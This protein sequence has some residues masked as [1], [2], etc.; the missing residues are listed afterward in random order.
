MFSHWQGH[1]Q[2]KRRRASAALN[3]YA[4]G[5]MSQDATKCHRTLGATGHRPTKCSRGGHPNFPWSVCHASA[6][7]RY[8]SQS[9]SHAAHASATTC[10][11]EE[12]EERRSTLQQQWQQTQPAEWQQTSMNSPNGET[13]SPSNCE[14][15]PGTNLRK[16]SKQIGCCHIS[17]GL[18]IDSHQHSQSEVARQSAHC[19]HNANWAGQKR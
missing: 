16:R 2:G 5:S 17:L 11:S 12:G 14:D 3:L 9:G 10:H 4:E 1:S 15:I 7:I 8:A 19:K 6:G 18:N 13:V